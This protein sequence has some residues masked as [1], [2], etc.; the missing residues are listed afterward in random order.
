MSAKTPKPRS[1]AV[2]SKRQAD[3]SAESRLPKPSSTQADGS[4]LISNA[5]VLDPSSERDS[6]A[7]IGIRDGKIA[8]VG[9]AKPREHYDRSFDAAGLWLLPGLVDL[10][11][12]FREPGQSHKASFASETL[13]AQASGI[14]HILLPPDTVPVI[15]SPA[16]LMRVQHIARQTGGLGVHVLGALTKGLGG[17]A[18]A[19]MSALKTAGAVGVSNGLLPVRDALIARRALE[20]AKGLGLRVHVFAQDSTLAAGGCAHEGAVATR[21]GLSPIPAAA[22]VAAIRFWIS[23]VEDTGASVHF[24][25]LSTAKGAGLIESAQKRGLPVTADV[26]VHQLFLI[27][28]DV[29]GFNAQCHLVPPLRSV[30]DRE[31][32]RAATRMGVIAALC[33]DHQPHEADAKINPFPMTEPG[34]SGLETLLPLTL[35]LVHEGIL[36]PLQAAARL[37]LGPARIAGIDAGRIEIGAPA[38]LVLVNPETEWTLRPERMLSAGRNTPFAGRSFRGRVQRCFHDGVEVFSAAQ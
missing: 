10:S 19:E 38:H 24:C 4:L 6:V 34:L 2:S 32:L 8:H 18:L 23:L 30:E 28:D 33:S 9:T 21:L 26:A 27:D 37:S 25:R 22:E 29:D 14:A 12:R 35:A 31:T 36:T 13:A 3:W 16:M 11:A 15:D 1:R 7:H 17:E 20:Y 5:R